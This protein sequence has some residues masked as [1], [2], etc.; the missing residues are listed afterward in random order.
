[1]QQGPSATLFVILDSDRPDAHRQ[2]PHAFDIARM[3]SW[4]RKSP[5]PFVVRIAEPRRPRVNV[6]SN[7]TDHRVS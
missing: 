6:T 5:T 1:M 7:V 2:Q 3:E 4:G